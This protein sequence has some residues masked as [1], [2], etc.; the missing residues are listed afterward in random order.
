MLE[1]GLWDSA[2]KISSFFEKRVW[3]ELSTFSA[4]SSIHTP[5]LNLNSV[6]SI[7]Y[8]SF[9]VLV[10]SLLA[11]ISAKY[12]KDLSELLINENKSL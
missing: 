4:D 11:W 9:L 5:I 2:P 12:E 8:T 10:S 3:I 1:I 7:H 6:I